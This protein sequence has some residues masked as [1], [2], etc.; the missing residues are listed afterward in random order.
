[1][2][3][4]Q[5]EDGFNVEDL[6]AV[7][8]KLL[9]A[10]EDTQPKQLKK[11]MQAEGNK[12][13]RKTLAKAKA[14]VTKRTDGK[15]SYFNSIKRGKVY[16]FKGDEVAVRVYSSAPHSHLIEYGHRMIKR[17]GEEGEFVEG[18]HVFSDTRKD[19][20]GQFIQDIE[21]FVTDKLKL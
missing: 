21:K 5:L 7:T 11:L 9:K 17:N 1:M 19:F 2:S 14:E 4:N 8:K 13:K 18:K 10:A 16:N 6:D 12:L 20:Q 3:R 15:K